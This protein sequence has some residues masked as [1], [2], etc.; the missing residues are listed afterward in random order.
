MLYFY[1]SR[2]F[3][4]KV[5]TEKIQFKEKLKLDIA[6]C[7]ILFS[8]AS[9]KVITHNVVCFIFGISSFSRLIFFLAI[10]LSN[11]TIFFR[12]DNNKILLLN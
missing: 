7:I 6:S 11:M 12:G 5:L 4:L 3:I 9:Y 2:I 8:I 10:A 1:V